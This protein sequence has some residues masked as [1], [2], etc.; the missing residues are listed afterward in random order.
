MG[1]P[2]SID[3]TSRIKLP[4]QV[5]DGLRAAIQC[6][7]YKPGERLP[8]SREMRAALGIETFGR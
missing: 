3:R 1:L 6:G 4:Y 5:A 7:V 2:F 8:S